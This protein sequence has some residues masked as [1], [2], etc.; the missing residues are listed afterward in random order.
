MTGEG[1]CLLV[2]AAAGCQCMDSQCS[3]PFQGCCFLTSPL[4]ALKEN[5]EA[6]PFINIRWGL[7]ETAEPVFG[8]FGQ[9][10]PL[11]RVCDD[12]MYLS[13]NAL[14]CVLHTQGLGFLLWA[15]GG[16]GERATC[17]S[18][19]CSVYL[20]HTTV[21]WYPGY[22]ESRALRKRL[23]TLEAGLGFLATRSQSPRRCCW[24]ANYRGSP[25][26]REEM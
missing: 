10:T 14:R 16:E 24:V 3:F 22:C 18:R 5:Q 13:G 26:Q 12:F 8:Q 1:I 23:E 21:D 15:E 9:A 20:G 25:S 4:L 7:K 11:A 2:P 6:I 17:A 19:T